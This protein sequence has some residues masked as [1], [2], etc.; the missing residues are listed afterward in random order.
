MCRGVSLLGFGVAGG[1]VGSV[2]A[3]S[4]Q[5]ESLRECPWIDR[6]RVVRDPESRVACRSCSA[7]DLSIFLS[8]YLSTYLSIALLLL[9]GAACGQQGGG[10]VGVEVF[11]CTLAPNGSE[12]ATLVRVR[13]RFWLVSVF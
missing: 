11:R 10:D 3:R 7:W 4:E 6:D 12:A 8:T 9:L 5:V 13:V 2:A 1:V